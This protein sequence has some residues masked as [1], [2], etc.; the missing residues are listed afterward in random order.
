[1]EH[2]TKR[3]VKIWRYFF[4]QWRD[5]KRRW[6]KQIRCAEIVSVSQGLEKKEIKRGVTVQLCVWKCM[7]LNL[8]EQWLKTLR[9]IEEFDGVIAVT[10]C[11]NLILILRTSSHCFFRSFRIW[12]TPSH[13]Y[14]L[15]NKSFF[16]TLI[17]FSIST[18]EQCACD[19]SMLL[20]C[21]LLLYS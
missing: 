20:I 15:S 11:R 18:M 6:E 17:W 2:S 19:R 1:M 9:R 13:S 10:C 5:W 4:K 16:Q 14:S 8:S 21:D 7:Y 3:Y 12:Q